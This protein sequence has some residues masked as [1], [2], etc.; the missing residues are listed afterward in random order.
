VVNDLTR[1]CLALVADTSLS[2]AR[3]ARERDAIAAIRGKPLAVVRDNGTELTSTSILRWFQERQMEL[4][5]I[6]PR[7]LN[8]PGSGRCRRSWPRSTG[9]SYPSGEDRLPRLG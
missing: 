7:H 1:E 4:H 9:S 2:D 6:V 8:R 5:Y 3:V